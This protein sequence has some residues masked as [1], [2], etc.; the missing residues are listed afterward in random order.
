MVANSKSLARLRSSNATIPLFTRTRAAP[1]WR[2]R[3]S[4]ALK[5]VRYCSAVNPGGGG[6][7]AALDVNVRWRCRREA[8]SFC[9]YLDPH[10]RTCLDLPFSLSLASKWRC[11]L[12]PRW[13][14][15]HPFSL[16]PR[17]HGSPCADGPPLVTLTR[18][19]ANHHHH[20]LMPLHQPIELQVKAKF[21]TTGV[22]IPETQRSQ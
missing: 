18:I 13:Q 11:P 3:S 8:A 2:P 16:G 7:N 17:F 15:A 9:A 4:H 22:T 10:R 5:M 20:A 6:T 1:A 14:G 21:A 19:S 12:E